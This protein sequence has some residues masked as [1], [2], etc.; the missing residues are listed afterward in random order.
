MQRGVSGREVV[1]PGNH[2]MGWGPGQPAQ[3][4]TLNSNTRHIHQHVCTSSCK[5]CIVNS[6]NT[7]HAMCTALYSSKLVNIQEVGSSMYSVEW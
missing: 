7:A 2:D 5:Y 1:S 6:I 4:V 3:G